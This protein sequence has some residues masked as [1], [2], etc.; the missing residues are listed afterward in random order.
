MSALLQG[1]APR[2]ASGQILVTLGTA[3][4]H[5]FHNGIPYEAD[6]SVAGR[7]VTPAFFHQGLPFD[8]AGRIA[9]AGTGAN[10]DFYGSGAAPFSSSSRLCPTTVAET[11]VSS[12]V[13]YGNGKIRYAVV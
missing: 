1:V 7:A 8:A 3:I 12:G 5:H 6:G 9:F 10:I 13:S 4:P 2:N 11:S